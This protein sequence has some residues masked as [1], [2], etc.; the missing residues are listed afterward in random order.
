MDFLL[1]DLTL[2]MTAM[3]SGRMKSGGWED[4]TQ[5]SSDPVKEGEKTQDSSL[6]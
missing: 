2:A 1:L 5:K 4:K 3:S 6:L